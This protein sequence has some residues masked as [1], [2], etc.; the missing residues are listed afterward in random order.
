MKDK[1]L[2][3]LLFVETV[4]VSIL[5]VEMYFQDKSLQKYKDFVNSIDTTTLTIVEK[6]TVYETKTLTD[7]VPQYITRWKTKRDTLFKY[8]ENDTIPHVVQLKSKTYCNTITDSNDTI[9]YHAHISGY[10]MDTQ[11]YPKLDSIE[12][13]L[14]RFV[15]QTNT[16]TKQVV[17][18]PQKQ[19]LLTT[20]P[21]VTLGYDPINK[22]WGAMVGL[23]L[24]F[25][26]WSK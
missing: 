17:K 18:V 5:L 25:N 15:T 16:T 22:Q 4:I 13:N 14:K 7:T 21:S 9:E 2:S 6:D 23:S 3:I 10:D 11:E 24:N 1:T 26:V 12:F 20:S 19:K 8:K